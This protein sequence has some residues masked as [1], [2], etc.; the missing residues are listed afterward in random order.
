MSDIIKLAE[1]MLSEPKE[2]QRS[3]AKVHNAIMGAF[4]S[5]KGPYRSK[6]RYDNSPIMNQLHYIVPAEHFNL[7]KFSRAIGE[8]GFSG[9]T[10]MATNYDS[11][12]SSG[13]HHYNEQ[14]RLKMYVNTEHG[15]PVNIHVHTY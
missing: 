13:A 11:M 10:R 15:G 14:D 2:M 7:D 12:T 1:S 4:P 5:A 3:P 9:D 8:A 6:Y